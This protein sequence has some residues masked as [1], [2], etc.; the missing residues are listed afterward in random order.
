MKTLD[1][2]K[3]IRPHLKHRV[4][5]LAALALMAFASSAAAAP[6]YQESFTTPCASAD[7]SVTYPGFSQSGTAVH[8][9][10]DGYA[11]TDSAAGSG[12]LWRTMPAAM[13]IYDWT[14]PLTVGL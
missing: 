8:V 4:L 14:L 12:G 6:L 11:S 5:P 1:V 10:A 9:N 7:F 2:I 3:P 13:S